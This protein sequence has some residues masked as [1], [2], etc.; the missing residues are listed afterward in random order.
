MSLKNVE[1]SGV[2]KRNIETIE[3]RLEANDTSLAG[4]FEL[5]LA[6]KWRRGSKDEG[7]DEKLI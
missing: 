5:L 7:F 6:R 4:G 3:Y 2:K 1:N